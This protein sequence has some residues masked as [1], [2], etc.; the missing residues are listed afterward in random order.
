M[1]K[2]MIKFKEYLS[3]EKYYS[4]KTVINYEL[5]LN[6]YL[7]FLSNKNL[8]FES[9]TKDDIRA[10][11]KYL[12]EL[13]YKNSSI[14]RHMSSIRSFYTYLVLTNVIKTNIF[15]MISNPKIPKKIPNFLYSNELDKLFS[16]CDLS[17]ALGKRNRLIL[18]MFYATGIR[19]GE[20]V[21]IKISHINQSDL[22][23]KITGK[24]KKDRVVYYGEYMSEALNQYL[25]NGRGELLK[26]KRHD[27]LFVNR[28]G[29]KITTN[30]IRD[31]MEKIIRLSGVKH[32][33]SPHV[34][35]HT[36]ATHL[37]ENGAD[38]KSVQELLGHE[39][40]TTTQIYT[41]VTSKK[42]KQILVA[43]HPRNKLSFNAG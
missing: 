28:F 19:I 42:Q 25:S 32:K 2:Y 41:H 35:R 21:E 29:N 18:E 15:K 17:T 37:L 6:N 1:E 3:K 24:G 7:D 13:K 31:V 10:Y 9:V 22:A 11:L 23:V 39:S 40:L 43:K 20:L 5:D 26:D 27:Y 33:I 30:G 16:A 14:A 36:F 12:N 38:L 4:D 8:D 34:L